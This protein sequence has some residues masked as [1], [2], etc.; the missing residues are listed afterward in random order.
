M[1]N[2]KGRNSDPSPRI[3]EMTKDPQQRKRLQEQ[4]KDPGLSMEFRQKILKVLQEPHSIVAG[5]KPQTESRSIA[6]L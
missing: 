2:N 1:R 4:L 3:Q 6:A 5:S